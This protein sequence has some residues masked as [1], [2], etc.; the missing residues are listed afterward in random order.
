MVRIKPLRNLGIKHKG[1]FHSLMAFSV[2]AFA[3]KYIVMLSFLNEFAW[4]GFIIG[5][6]S[7]L[8]IDFINQKRQRLLFPLK[9]K[10]GI[11]L[12][13]K[14]SKVERFIFFTMT[15]LFF[16]ILLYEKGIFDVWINMLL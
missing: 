11:R 12:V 7:H 8:L 6:G 9:S 2:F 4:Y 16:L 15:L 3:L 13:A 14:N 5:Y 10:I 1:F